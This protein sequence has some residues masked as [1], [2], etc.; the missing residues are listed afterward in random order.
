MFKKQKRTTEDSDKEN[1]ASSNL[2]TP[3]KQQMSPVA[4]IAVEKQQQ[5]STYYINNITNNIIYEKPKEK[6]CTCCLG[7][8]FI[9]QPMFNPFMMGFGGYPGS[10]SPFEM[11][12]SS[13]YLN[14]P[15][16]FKFH[17]NPLTFDYSNY[18]MRPHEVSNYKSGGETPMFMQAA[19]HEHNKIYNMVF[20]DNK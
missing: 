13:D 11:H 3:P 17:E 12:G 20:Q 7:K 15:P 10:S 5:D 14:S 6:V 2:L 8:G 1:I 16:K 18:K 19:G 4:P 9:M